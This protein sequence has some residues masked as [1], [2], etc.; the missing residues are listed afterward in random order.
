MQSGVRQGTPK[1][2]GELVVTLILESAE[3]ILE[4]LRKLIEFAPDLE[5]FVDDDEES[6]G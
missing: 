3:K 5:E 4:P 2:E 1:G 6:E